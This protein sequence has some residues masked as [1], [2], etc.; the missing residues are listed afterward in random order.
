M[1]RRWPK[2]VSRPL[3][4][5]APKAR[6]LVGCG[7]PVCDL[8]VVIVDAQTCTQA[9]PGRVGEIW[10]AG[11]SVAQGYWHK[12]DQTGRSF[13]ARLSDTGEGPFL[14]TGDLGFLLEGQLYITGRLDDM[15]IVRGLNHH[16]QDL[17][18][19]AR[20]SH[21]LLEAGFGAAFA[22]DVDG[23]QRL[24]LVLEV[25]L[26]AEANFTLVLKAAREAV[27]AEH[28]L[29]LHTIMLVRGGTIPKTSSG[30]VQ[31]RACRTAFLAGEL[32]ALAEN[33]LTVEHTDAAV[34]PRRHA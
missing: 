21:P 15:L 9:A 12:P 11:A 1:T 28:G 6:Q 3:P 25:T 18:A 30:K 23:G 22:V 24:V 7:A 31:R 34:P 2:T 17:E 8:C 27:L 19:T 10:I 26:T 14:R 33:T 4:D 16:P 5:D 20:Q 13:N 32:K 29:A